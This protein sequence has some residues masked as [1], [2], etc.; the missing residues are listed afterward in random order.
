LV[1]VELIEDTLFGGRSVFFFE[2]QSK[3]SNIK[4]Q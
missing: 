1:E 3:F 2:H 4:V